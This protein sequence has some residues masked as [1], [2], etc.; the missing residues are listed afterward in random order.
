MQTRSI[1]VPT[2]DD[3]RRAEQTEQKG[4]R[5]KNTGNSKS[6]KSNRT[7]TR[8]KTK[9]EKKHTD[10]YVCRLTIQRKNEQAGMLKPQGLGLAETDTQNINVGKAIAMTKKAGI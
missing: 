9:V 4:G 8:K 5:E 6:T 10:K 7:P 3:Q 1:A 2:R